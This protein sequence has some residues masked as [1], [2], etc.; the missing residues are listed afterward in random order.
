VPE[1]FIGRSKELASLR[2]VFVHAV[3]D[4]HPAVVVVAGDA[5]SGKSA[6]LT[7]FERVIDAPSRLRA[8]GF[9][10]EQNVPLACARDL[11]AELARAP[12][13]ESLRDLVFA[14]GSAVAPIEQLR[15]FEAAYRA[16]VGMSPLLVVVDDLQWV[17]AASLALLHYLI[18]AAEAD[19]QA[20]VVV[21]AAR[22]SE[23]AM[24]FVDGCSRTLG[25]DRVNWL[26]LGPLG[27]EDGVRLARE[28]APTLDDQQVEA[29]W[30]RAE[31]S[32]FWL[33]VLAAGRDSEER[34]MST[35]GRRLA[36]LGSDGAAL[37]A[38]L[39][40]AERPLILEDVAEIQRWPLH[41]LERTL[42]VL[43]R[44]GL[45]VR[46]AGSVMIA[47]DL[48]RQAVLDTLAPDRFRQI[49]GLLER[50]WCA[51]RVRTLSSC[52]GASSTLIAVGPT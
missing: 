18:R 40:V 22:R 12:G 3:R 46:D 45:A 27:R 13:G 37:G 6:L 8:A 48:V 20:L 44:R 33:G 30:R 29:L 38:L 10:L 4:R 15:V 31:G 34:V 11:L 41:R 49:H 5:G 39:A 26:E 2:D 17:D 16:M 23:A 1:W 9:E 47:H 24:E 50:G 43:E 21:S 19:G 28:L 7:E 25:A 14:G 35:V 52:S 51:V 42:L 36:A 32:P